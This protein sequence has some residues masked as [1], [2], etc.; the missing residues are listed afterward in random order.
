MLPEIHRP[1]CDVPLRPTLCPRAHVGVCVCVCVCV[2]GGGGCVN[3]PDRRPR[4]PVP[5]WARIPTPGRSWCW[6]NTRSSSGCHPAPGRRCCSARCRSGFSPA[7]F[8]SGSGRVGRHESERVRSGGEHLVVMIELHCR[9]SANLLSVA[10]LGW[11]TQRKILR[12]TQHYAQSVSDLS[13]PPVQPVRLLRYIIFKYVGY[14][15]MCATAYD[16]RRRTTRTPFCTPTFGMLHF[17]PGPVPTGF[18]FGFS[19]RF[20]TAALRPSTRCYD[21]PPLPPP[22]H[23][24]ETRES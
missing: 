9:R 14:A 15:C 1:R 23:W 13:S 3:S 4:C 11:N 12:S 2:F 20:R 16:A 6:K 24:P 10:R 18:G 5:T 19:T 21:A 17:R 22:I 7:S 8:G